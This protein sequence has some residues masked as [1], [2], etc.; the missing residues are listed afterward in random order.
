[1]RLVTDKPDSRPVVWEWLAARN[2]L[3]WSTDLRV[4]GAERD[5]GTIAAAVGFNVWTP[6]ACWMHVAFDS[7]HSLTRQLL[8]AAFAYPF[9]EHGAEAVYGLTP[10]TF[11]AAVR[12][13]ERI[14]MRPVFE[15][16]DSVL[17]ELRR[18][19]CRFLKELH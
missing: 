1:M 10:R 14:G 18:E 3:P 12:F 9:H 11:D 17:F 19:D 5:D 15:T 7:P 2:N 16:V 8:T 6:K 4:I 13:N